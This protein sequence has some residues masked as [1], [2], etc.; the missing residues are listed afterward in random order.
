M[1]IELLNTLPPP[2][3]EGVLVSVYNANPEDALLRFDGKDY[4]FPAESFESIEPEAAFFFFGVETRLKE[5]HGTKMVIDSNARKS[6]RLRMGAQGAAG[7]TWIN[8]FRIKLVKL[9]KRGSR[10]NWGKLP[11]LAEL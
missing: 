1:P 8:N 3:P 4:V 2:W 9:G 5:G 6:A 11:A 7:E 10:E